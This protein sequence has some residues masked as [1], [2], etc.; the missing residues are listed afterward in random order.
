MP[1]FV[2]KLNLMRCLMASGRLTVA[3]LC[4]PVYVRLTAPLLSLTIVIDRTANTLSFNHR[5]AATGLRFTQQQSTLH[6]ITVC[7]RTMVASRVVTHAD[8]PHRAP[9]A[10]F[11]VTKL[12]VM[13]RI[14]AQHQDSSPFLALPAGNCL[15]FSLSCGRSA[16]MNQKFTTL[17][18]TSRSIRVTLADSQLLEH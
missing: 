17:S 14:P 6:N 8:F 5:F 4:I 15:Q 11:Y 12:E 13:A 10:S 16:H 1:G 9:L 18:T 7:I 3:E 2:L